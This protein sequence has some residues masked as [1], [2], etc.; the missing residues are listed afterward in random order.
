M[1]VNSIETCA[2]EKRLVPDR[3]DAAR[4]GDGGEVCAIV[5]RVVSDG[6]DVGGNFD[7]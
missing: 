1:N 6:G 5:E 3:G 4:N 7:G 2:P